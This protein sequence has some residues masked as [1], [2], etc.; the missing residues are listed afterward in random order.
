VLATAAPPSGFD[1]GAF[2]SAGDF[3]TAL[4]DKELKE[5]LSTLRASVIC[6]V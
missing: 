4:R 1:I 5:Q 2:L 6:A 3:S